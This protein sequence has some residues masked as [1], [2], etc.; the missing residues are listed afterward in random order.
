[1]AGK[2]C[3]GSIQACSLRMG[4]LDDVGNPLVGVHDMI[5]TDSLIKIDWKL[6]LKQGV[7]LELTNGCGSTCVTFQDDDQIESVDLT[8]ELCTLDAELIELATG[9]GLVTIGG[10]SV[11]WTLPPVGERLDQRVSVEAWSKAWDV[12]Q[13]ASSGGNALYHHWVW[14]SV[15]WVMGDSGIGNTAQSIPFTGHGRSNSNIG[16]GIGGDLP[17][18]VFVTPMGEYVDDG[19]LPTATCGYLSS[20]AS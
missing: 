20:P 1:M 14:P 15:S 8:M 19:G 9:A 7:K 18:A 10:Q 4:R 13:Q 12:D 2:Q 6:I 5:V 3:T 16:D 11:G 17:S